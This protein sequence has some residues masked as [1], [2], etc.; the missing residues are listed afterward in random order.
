MNNDY[1]NLIFLALTTL[2][3]AMLIGFCAGT[4]ERLCL[5]ASFG[6]EYCL[7]D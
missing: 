5:T 1:L 6:A 7:S 4:T 2:V 3:I